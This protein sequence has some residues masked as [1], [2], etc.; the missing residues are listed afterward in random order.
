LARNIYSEN[1][2]LGLDEIMIVNPAPGQAGLHSFG[3]PSQAGIPDQDPPL[4]LGEDGTLYGLFGPQDSLL[5]G[6]FLLGEDGRF[7]RVAIQPAN[8]GSIFLG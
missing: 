5:E 2:P 4:F 8:G 3:Y 1:Q 6:D 7:Y